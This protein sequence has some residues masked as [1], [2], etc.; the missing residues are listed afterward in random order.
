MSSVRE[1]LPTG[2]VT[3][4]FT[5]IEGSTRLLR[6]LGV[7]D[8]AAALQEHRRT[9]RGAVAAHRGV[10]VDTEGDAFFCVF[11]TAEAAARAARAAQAGLANG[12]IRVRMG[13]H[14]GTAHLT[15]EG[16]V[17]EDVHLAA[18]ISA[19][20]H[21]GQVV[22]SKATRE[23]LGD[24]TLTDLGEHLL[25]DFPAPVWLY[26][27]GEERFP[28]L[29]TRSNTNLPRPVSSF[30]GREREVGEVTALLRNGGRIVTLSGPGGSGKTRLAIEA[31][32]GLVPEFGSGVFWV[33]LAPLRDPALVVNAIAET[34]GAE[35]D[36][37]G[38]LATRELLLLL[39]NFEQVV[40]AAPELSALLETCPDVR[41][42]VTSRALLRVDGEVAYPVDPLADPDAVELFCRR[43]RVGADETVEL[44]CRRLDNLPL[45]LELAAARACVLSPSQIVERLASRL[46]LLRAGRGAEA[47][48]QTRP[49]SGRMT[50][51]TIPSASCSRGWPCSVAGAGSRRR[52]RWPGQLSTSSSLSS[53][54]A[55]FAT[56]RS[57]S[58]CSRRSA[59]T[60]ESDSRSRARPNGFA[61]NMPRTF[62][63][64]CVRS[65]VDSGAPSRRRTSI[66]STRRSTT[67]GPRS[68][69]LSKAARPSSEASSRRGSSA[70]GGCGERPRE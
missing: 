57:V 65:R 18:R 2:T 11:E 8:Y 26:Q 49:S 31:A 24:G 28:P 23:L 45:A 6:E 21:G 58:G 48:Q 52:S 47:R 13:M 54:R 29:R 30:V 64:S 14:T 27:V 43:A 38:F 33:G 59:S 32:A 12:R 34:L 62:S 7:S 19:V 67:S 25:K 39:D 60:R 37:E 36:L 10:E 53:R 41:V 40:D 51:S 3:F 44:L 61:A 42:L 17:G 69:G 22:L 5:D 46:D 56:P 63:D 1:A 50:F 4:L 9:V 35:D 15:D 68:S 16:Y 70:T 20:G 55:W 66:A